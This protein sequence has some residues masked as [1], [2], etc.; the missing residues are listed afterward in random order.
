MKD[1]VRFLVVVLT[2]GVFVVGHSAQAE[3]LY[4]DGKWANL[5]IDRKASEIGDI[6]TVAVFQTV[7]ARN[8]AQNSSR[9][10]NDIS[11]TIRGGSHLQDGDISFGGRFSGSG[12]IRR[13]GSIVAQIGVEVV[14]IFDNGDLQI[15]GEQIVFVNGE[16]TIIGVR[17]RV[18]PVDISSANVVLSNRIA[19]AEIEYDGSGFVSRS[20]RP[21]I[22]SRIFSFLGLS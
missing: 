13:S 7:E 19:N 6:L 21:G 12:E 22:I 15:Q 2:V 11:G 8:A 14:D 4:K 1:L 9:K 3:N 5:A 20:A 16:Q 18:R 17:G 10:Q